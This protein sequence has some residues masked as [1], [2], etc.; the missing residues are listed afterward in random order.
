MR[1]KIESRCE[2]HCSTCISNVFLTFRQHCVKI[3][4]STGSCTFPV[5]RT[6]LTVHSFNKTCGRDFDWGGRGQERM[7]EAF[8]PGSH[9]GH[10]VY[11]AL[12]T[13]C[14]MAETNRY[15]YEK[16]SVKRQRISRLRFSSLQVLPKVKYTGWIFWIRVL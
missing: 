12:T 2:S 13:D 4:S 10:F 8:R 14:E 5:K 16:R 6:R 9:C 7:N 11:F 1:T 3:C 15:L